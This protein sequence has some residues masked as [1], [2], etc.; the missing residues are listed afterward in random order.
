MPPVLV[1][2]AGKGAAVGQLQPSLGPY[3]ALGHFE[4]LW[5]SDEA[6]FEQD[7]SASLAAPG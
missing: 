2:K 3:P 5:G 1:V 7:R 6:A 4:G